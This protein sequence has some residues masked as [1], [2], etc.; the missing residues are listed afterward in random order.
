MSDNLSLYRTMLLIRRFEERL[1]EEFSAGRLFGTT[2]AYIGQEADAAG[3]FAVAGE[4]DPVFSSH[5]CHG[6]SWLTP[7]ASPG[8]MLPT[9]WPPS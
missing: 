3:I 6:H 8:A 9:A 4:E 7:A 1:L 2:H 5:R